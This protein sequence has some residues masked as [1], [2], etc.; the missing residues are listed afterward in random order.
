[1]ENKECFLKFEAWGES[2]TITKDHSDIT[3]EDFYLM[4]RQISTSQF[5]EKNTKEYFGKL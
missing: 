1:M 5:G 2:I 3:A 4:C